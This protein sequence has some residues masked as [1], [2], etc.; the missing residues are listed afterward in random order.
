MYIC[1]YICVCMYVYKYVFMYVHVYTYTHWLF[2]II[3]SKLF[4]CRWFILQWNKR[5]KW[6][7]KSV[8]SLIFE[9]CLSW[10]FTVFR[11]SVCI[12]ILKYD[13]YWL[14]IGFLFR[15]C[16]GFQRLLCTGCFMAD[17]CRICTVS[18]EAKADSHDWEILYRSDTGTV[19]AILMTVHP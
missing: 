3:S 2:S 18:I 9:L 6:K 14:F 13:L 12:G 4:I 1:V 19:Q 16:N 7:K 15:L 5:V 10:L 8:V 11:Y 17:L